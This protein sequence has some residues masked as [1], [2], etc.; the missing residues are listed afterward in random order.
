VKPAGAL[1]TLASQLMSMTNGEVESEEE[2]VLVEPLVPPT[3]T[4]PR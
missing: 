2:T 4:A 3:A 1:L